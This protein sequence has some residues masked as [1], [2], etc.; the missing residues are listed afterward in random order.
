MSDNDPEW[1]TALERLARLERH[2][3]EMRGVIYEG[4]AWLRP[5]YTEPQVL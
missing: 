1:R 3:G 5:N 2:V 4:P